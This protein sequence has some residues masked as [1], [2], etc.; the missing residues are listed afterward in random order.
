MT[1]F[2]T[3]ST[4]DNRKVFLAIV[5]TVFITAV[6]DEWYSSLGHF[7]RPCSWG[8][9]VQRNSFFQ[10]DK[11]LKLNENQFTYLP[12]QF[13]SWCSAA[14]HWWW[15]WESLLFNDDDQ[16]LVTL[17]L[18]SPMTKATI[19]WISISIKGHSSVADPQ[20]SPSS[21]LK[22]HCKMGKN[23]WQKVGKGK[24]VS[25]RQITI[26]WPCFMIRKSDDRCLAC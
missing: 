12:T 15:W 14:L 25:G 17:H 4:V 10:L 11:K 24:I 6:L 13:Y 23:V 20:A 19:A 3:S 18:D 21:I 9:R 8:H 26:N 22:L 16:G 5:A 1:L 2:F 7:F